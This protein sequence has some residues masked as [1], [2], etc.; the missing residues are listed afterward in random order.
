MAQSNIGIRFNVDV[1][2]A[3]GQVDELSKT[4]ADLTEKIAK[5]RE[6]G[7]WKE[8]AQLTMAMDNA[9]SARGKVMQQ[10]RQTQNTQARENM[11]NSFMQGA[12]WILFQNSLNQITQGIIKSMDSALTA[13]K[14][15]A[16]GDYAGASVTK[17]RAEG[18]ITGQAIGTGIGA[19]GFLVNPLLGALLMGVGGELGKFLGGREAKKVEANLA[20]ADQYKKILPL[21]DN[22]NQLYGGE[23]NNKSLEENNR[24]GLEMYGRATAATEG[25]GLSTQE[26]IEAMKQTGG[27]G[28]RDETMALNMAQTQALWSRFTGTDL[29]TIQK[30]AGQ[31]YRYGNNENA[32]STAYGGLMAQGMGKGQFGE[33]LNSMERILEEGIAKG[34]IRSSEEIAGNM[35]ML[36]KLSGGSKLWQG[37]QGANRLNQ[38]NAAI[39]NA[40]NLQ[41][42]EDVISFGVAREL[43]ETGDRKANFLKYGGKEG[44]YTDSYVDVMTMLERGVSPNLLKGQFE[45]VSRLEGDNAAGI[46]ERFKSMYGLNY[47][48]ARDVWAMMRG[49]RDGDGNFNFN[50]EKFANQIKEMQKK[51]EFQSDSAKLQTA[52]NK[53]TDNLANVGKFHFDDTEW[54]FLKAQAA[55]VEDILAEIRGDKKD[56]APLPLP[57]GIPVDLQPALAD[58]LYKP[59]SFWEQIDTA[60]PTKYFLEND[61]HS[62]AF[63]EATMEETG[64]SFNDIINYIMSGKNPNRF[65]AN[66]QNFLDT[67]MVG[68][69]TAVIDEK[70]YVATMEMLKYSLHDL[71]ISMNKLREVQERLLGEGIPITGEIKG[72]LD[73]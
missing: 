18:E 15:R 17:M 48:G 38:M 8:V 52:L 42:V 35:Q 41:S 9:T 40:T 69:K 50:A 62:R 57:G 39:S 45:A 61:Q 46:I 23:I 65:D 56:P 29:S 44:D 64:K 30:F 43:L 2:Q 12:T 60:V 54:G 28:I 58:E 33:F 10:A 1:S 37:E 66:F 4:V 70:E 24:Y 13:A 20:F 47:N 6:V 22:L 36:Y 34:F 5:A 49:A 72:E 53:M 7:D 16:S 11:Q 63:I 21:L 19:L 27:Y 25:T 73:L 3:K 68:H 51:P 55:T 71:G 67:A 31:S 26:F 32:V 14:Q 59:R